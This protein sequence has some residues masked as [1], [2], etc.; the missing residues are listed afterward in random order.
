MFFVAG[1]DMVKKLLTV[2]NRSFWDLWIQKIFRNLAS[3]KFQLLIL[4]Y[5]PIIYGMFDGKWVK[6]VWQAKI[7]AVVGLGFLGGGYVTLALGRIYAQTKLEDE[8]T[9]TLDDKNIE[10]LDTE[11]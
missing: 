3:L 4:L 10:T 8:D 7:S 9:E 11:S 5:I 1:G 2:Y 6:D